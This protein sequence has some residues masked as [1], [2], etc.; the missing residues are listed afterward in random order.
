MA[1][2]KAGL[3][4]AGMSVAWHVRMTRAREEAGK[5]RLAYGERIS[6]HVLAVNL[7]RVEGTEEDAFIVM[8]MPDAVEARDAVLAA[9]HR[10][11]VE[12]A[13]ARAQPSE[14]LD[15][16]REAVGQVGARPAVELH[17][18]A[19]LAGDHPEAVVLDLMQPLFAGRR[20]WGWGRQARRY[21]TRRQGTRTQPLVTPL[22][23][24]KR[25]GVKLRGDWGARLM[26]RARHLLSL[27]AKTVQPV[28]EQAPAPHHR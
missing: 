13:G 10:L 4:A 23:A 27:A 16:E 1:R 9:R 5:R 2:M 22:A 7:D 11:A 3:D 28:A 14:R 18:L 15:D 26:A 12:D 21:E 25:R 19:F 20:L 8:P 6:A 17:P 24:V